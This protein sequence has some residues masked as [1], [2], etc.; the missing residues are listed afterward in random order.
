MAKK[1]LALKLMEKATLAMVAAIEAFNRPS[2]EYRGETFALL[3][4]NAWELLLKARVIQLANNKVSAIFIFEN[5]EL[6]GSTAAKKIFSKK[7][8]PSLNRSGTPKTISPK[9]AIEKINAS[10][11]PLNP[12]IKP[13][14]ETLLEIRDASAHFMV[15]SKQLDF[16]ITGVSSA[17]VSNF[18]AATKEWF[19]KDSSKK[20]SILLPIGFISANH[21]LGATVSTSVEEKNLIKFID[22]LNNQFC[23]PHGE[24]QKLL[25]HSEYSYSLRMDFKLYK[26][27]LSDCSTKIEIVKPGTP[28]AS[29]LVISTE[30]AV[31]TSHPW[32]YQKLV[33]EIKN[34]RPSI[35]QGKAFNL[36]FKGLK[37]TSQCIVRYWDVE[38]NSGPNIEYYSMNAISEFL[39][40]Y[41]RL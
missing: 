4:L 15:T 7:T 28:G 29:K 17:A 5:K 39:K 36:A 23:I 8:T 33:K 34:K 3:A 22:D 24:A 21:N 31:K 19:K 32:R 41:D 38:K 14:V 20:L 37:K 25:G 10:P 16:L 12:S 2:A 35:K 30:D 1:T 11:T 40:I 27:P 6:K 26:T 13:N 18:I 9:Q